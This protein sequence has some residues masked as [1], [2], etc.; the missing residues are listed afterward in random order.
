MFISYFSLMSLTMMV[1]SACVNDTVHLLYIL[2]FK[3][4]LCWALFHHVTLSSPPAFGGY[5]CNTKVQN[6]FQCYN[7]FVY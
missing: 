3:S 1:F 2:L 6:R 7:K 5:Q 4:C